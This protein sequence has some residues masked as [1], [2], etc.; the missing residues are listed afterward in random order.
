MKMRNL[1]IL[2]GGG[3][4]KNEKYEKVYEVISDF[5]RKLDY[6]NITIQGWKGQ[7]SFGD[8]GFINM[9]E[10]T[11]AAIELLK[12][13]EESDMPYD[14]IGRS[15]G[16]GVFLSLCQKLV[17]KNI[18]FATLWGM[19][20]YTAF[21]ELYREG[22][23]TERELSKNKGLNI[24][25]TFFASVIPFEIL[26]ARLTQN[27]SVNIVS[28]SADRV[29]TPAFS[30]FMKETNKEKKN[31]RFSIIPDL[32]HEVPFHHEEYLQK[33]FSLA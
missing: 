30:K 1:I 6:K 10:A 31:V 13:A 15:F 21:Y 8:I 27:F 28:G 12:G 16:T 33:L 29:C 23:R 18:G 22:I 9:T 24:D 14:V 17:L 11:D 3:D 5:G 4:P 26:L 7:F 32:P 25:E 2:S 20:S 19:P